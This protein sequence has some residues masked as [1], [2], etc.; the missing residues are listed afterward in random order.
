MAFRPWP[1]ARSTMT[2]T[3]RR[4]IRRWSEAAR[5]LRQNCEHWL[6]RPRV[7]PLKDGV[8]VVVAGPPNAGKSS[9]V[10]AIAGEERAIVTAV[11]GNHAR[12][13]RS[14][15]GA[16]RR[17]DS[18]DR[19]RGAAGRPRMKSRRLASRAPR[20]WSKRAD[21]LVWLGDAATRPATRDADPCAC[22]GRP[23]GRC[24][25]RGSSHSSSTTGDGPQGLAA[26]RIVEAARACC[27]RRARSRSTGARR[28]T[29]PKRRRRLSPRVG[30]TTV[31]VAE[32]LARRAR[33]L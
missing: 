31:L 6:E 32:D 30:A 12:P 9:L 11:P 19:H 3:M 20:L 10:N 15:A 14:S 16:R 1:S 22:Q 4:S 17:A 18:A 29:W 7:E 28:G 13:Y 21:V 27:R 25:R 23:R 26:G 5:R 24:E 2:R 33:G 8:R